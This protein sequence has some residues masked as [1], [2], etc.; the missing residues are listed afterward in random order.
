MGIEWRRMMS[1]QQWSWLMINVRGNRERNSLLVSVGMGWRRFKYNKRV[2]WCFWNR[3]LS[4]CCREQSKA[5][6]WVSNSTQTGTLSVCMAETTSQIRLR[7]EVVSRKDDEEEESY[8]KH[9]YK[10]DTSFRLLYMK[11][12]RFSSLEIL[13]GWIY[14]LQMNC[15][16]YCRRLDQSWH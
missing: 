4:T 15:E 1:I 11:S 8:Q 9:N 2:R 16:F 14:Y 10:V 5:F 13:T 12:G 6:T 7:V 3:L